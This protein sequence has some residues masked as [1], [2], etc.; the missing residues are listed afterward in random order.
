M[1]QSTDT[2]V[3]IDSVRA[4]LTK[5]LRDT[6]NNKWEGWAGTIKI[7]GHKVNIDLTVE[8]PE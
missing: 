5:V 6:I 4:T 8:Y 2:N 7:A 1:S 3:I